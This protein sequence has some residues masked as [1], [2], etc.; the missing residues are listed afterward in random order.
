[1]DPGFVVT[2]DLRSKPATALDRGPGS[3]FD[4]PFDFTVAAFLPCCSAAGLNRFEMIPLEAPSP[5]VVTDK[6]GV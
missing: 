4:F 2:A 3:G 5:V 6:E 1:L